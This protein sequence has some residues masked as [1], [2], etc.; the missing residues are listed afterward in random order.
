MLWSNVV[1]GNTESRRWGP[2]SL[3]CNPGSRA[4]LVAY[5]WGPQSGSLGQVLGQGGR[6]GHEAFCPIWTA[7]GLRFLTST[8]SPG[9]T[10]K[11]A[12]LSAPPILH[13]SCHQP[14]HS[15]M[16][17]DRAQRGV[18]TLEELWPR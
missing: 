16:S 15:K 18:P 10:T 13:P 9:L 1:D 6:G 7:P 4:V 14:G 3:S 8:A 12:W 11:A 17:G 2:H 5:A